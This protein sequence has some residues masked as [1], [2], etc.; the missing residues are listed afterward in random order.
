LELLVV[1]VNDDSS[2]SRRDNRQRQV[3][4]S[5][6][7]FRTGP[8]PPSVPVKLESAKGGFALT[9]V[10]LG[11]KFYQITLWAQTQASHRKWIDH[12]AEQQELMRQRSL[13]FD[14]EMLSENFFVGPNKVNCAAPF[15]GGRKMVYGT[16]DGVYLSDG[17][18]REP[19][20]VL[21]LLDVTQVDVLEEYQLLLVLSGMLGFFK[22]L[23]YRNTHLP[24][25]TAS[26]HVSDELAKP[27]RHDG[28]AQAR[29]ADQLAHKLLQGRL[30]PRPTAGLCC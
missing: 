20:K 14:T 22:N 1:S 7:A 24:R 29:E 28:W 13:M 10:H 5:K 17:K 27:A 21:A 4:V 12:I 26:N 3:V 19:V 23:L 30:L 18:N 15:D 8:H 6:S 25:R 9:F 2:S 11:R 16:D